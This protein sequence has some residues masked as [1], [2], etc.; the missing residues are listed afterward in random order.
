MGKNQSKSNR[1]PDNIEPRSTLVPDASGHGP[2]FCKSCWFERR[3]L[4]KCH[5]HYLCM[6]CLTL[7][8]TISD[9]CPICKYP[10]PTK[11]QLPKTPTAPHETA[12][13]PPPY[14]P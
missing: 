12:H 13:P 3:G 9:R 5:D 10:L 6:N 8:L 11:L 2:E 4:V 1:T 14:S 7:L